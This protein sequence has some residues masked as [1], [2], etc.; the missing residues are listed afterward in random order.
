MVG[1]R[2]R[3]NRARRWRR[4]G[5]NWEGVAAKLGFYT[6]D[7]QGLRGSISFVFL[8]FLSWRRIESTT[9]LLLLGKGEISGWVTCRTSARLPGS[10]HAH[11]QC[12]A[13]VWLGWCARATGEV[14]RS[15]WC[16]CTDKGGRKR[17][18]SKLGLAGLDLGPQLLLTIGLGRRERWAAGEEFS[19][20]S[21]FRMEY[22]W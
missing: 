10:R 5:G 4:A 13:T 20:S 11:A 1:R 3:G 8:A 21:Q 14:V 2:R 19:L 7:S 18:Y 6:I 9:S 15:P 16:H 12:G 22:L 17:Q